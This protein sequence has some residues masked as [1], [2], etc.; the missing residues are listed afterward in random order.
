MLGNSMQGFPHIVSTTLAGGGSQSG[1]L[2][3]RKE[4]QLQGS[5]V[6]KTSTALFKNQSEKDFHLFGQAI[7]MV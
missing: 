5:R 6:R 2:A 7:D 1:E 3:L 4:R